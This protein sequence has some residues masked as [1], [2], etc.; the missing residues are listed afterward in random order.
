MF[1]A[2]RNGTTDAS[3]NCQVN[4]APIPSGKPASTEL[5]REQRRAS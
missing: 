5:G 3:C 1:D 4:D 2:S